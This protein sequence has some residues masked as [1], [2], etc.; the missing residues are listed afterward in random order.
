MSASLAFDV[1]RDF[2][3][4]SIRLIF[5]LTALWLLAGLGVFLL[6]SSSAAVR[7]RAWALSML[8]ALLLPVV[9]LCLPEIRLGWIAPAREPA[10]QV[11]G[12]ADALAHDGLDRTAPDSPEAFARAAGAV[13]S[14]SPGEMPAAFLATSSDLRENEF[15]SDSV[16]ETPRNVDRVIAGASRLTVPPVR[17]KDFVRWWPFFVIAPTL[18]GLSRIVRALMGARSIVASSDPVADPACWQLLCDVAARLAG[19]PTETRTRT[20]PHPDLQTEVPDPQRPALNVMLRQ[21]TQTVVPLCVGWRH[22]AII[23]PADWR[24][25]SPKTLRAVF[26]H[27]LSHVVRAD[28]AWQLLALFACALY[29]FHPLAWLAARR[30]RTERESA[31]DDGVLSAGE[32]PA[33]YARILVDI[34]ERL[35]VSPPAPAVAVA[36]AARADLEHRICGIMAINRSRLPVG[37]RLGRTL[38]LTMLATAVAVGIL[39]PFTRQSIEAQAALAHAAPPATTADDPTGPQPDGG[40]ANQSQPASEP[41]VVTGEVVQADGTPVEGTLVLLRDRQL[42]RATTDK[43][44]RFRFDNIPPGHFSI[45]AHKDELAS[46]KERLVGNPPAKDSEKG[47]F[48]HIRLSMQPG[49]QVRFHVV[50]AVTGLPLEGTDIRFGFPDRRHKKTDREGTAIVAGLLPEKYEIWVEAADHAREEREIDLSDSERVTSQSFKLAAGGSVHGTVR[51]ESGN[52]LPNASVTYLSSGTPSS[53]RGVWS[54][55]TS[56]TTDAQGAFHHLHLPLN[57]ATKVSVNLEDYLPQQTEVTL[58]DRQREQQLEIRLQRRPRGGS[59]AGVVTDRDGRPLAGAKVQNSGNN[60]NQKRET[61]TDA[62]GR[63]VLHDL[64]KGI[65]G[66]EVVVRSPRFAPVMQ[67]VEPGAEDAPGYV[68]VRLLPGHAIRGRVVNEAGEPLKSAYVSANGY[69]TAIGETVRTN[70]NGEFEF[71]SLPEKSKFQIQANGYPLIL[72]RPLPLDGNEVVVVT[73]ESSVVLQ[74]RVLDSQTSKPI[75]EFRVRGAFSRDRLANDAKGSYPNELAAGLKFRSPE[76]AFAIK[77]LTRGVPLELVFEADGYE[78]VII[79]RVVAGTSEADRVKEIA[80]T[81][82]DDSR[83]STLAGKIVDH[84]VKPLAGVQIRLVVTAEPA[85]GDDDNRF[86]W[87]LIQGNQLGERSYVEQYLSAVSDADGKFEFRNLVP[88]KFLQIAYWGEGAPQGRWLALGKTRAG[89]GQS[90]IIKVPAPAA[91]RGSFDAA[92]FQKARE[93]QLNDEGPRN[94]FLSFKVDLTEGQTEFRFDNLPPGK[95]GLHLVG[96]LVRHEDNPQMFKSTPL[97]VRR[98]TIEPGKTYDIR[99]TEEDRAKQR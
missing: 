27:E 78:R 11:H 1:I 72:D 60:P 34:A 47:V 85:T 15:T 26:A 92:L 75:D 71:D 46:P 62:D 59:I 21:S 36:M 76:G 10:I 87:F 8:A 67:Q 37:R 2:P 69:G 35:S 80:L 9:L 82:R 95:Y 33:V 44:G 12:Q 7:H 77:E 94:S 52:P 25:W 79:P 17:D 93:V 64:L 45:W 30:M 50:S 88:A 63:F 99:L 38:G 18:W 53:P 43:Q 96:P 68:A 42:F 19:V 28:V 16:V 55:G 20:F 97:A 74:G 13:A 90:T 39:S 31:C 29:W 98:F 54:H 89:E 22:P 57:A 24:D 86:N 4:W 32:S 3:Q 83:Q 6:R 48:P 51:D 40:D 66:Y 84:E 73:L 70:D 58:T 56:F 49:R 41:G 81:R 23:L 61:T 65:A 91:V 5:S 14:Q